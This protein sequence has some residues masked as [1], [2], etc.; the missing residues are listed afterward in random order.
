MSI[1]GGQSTPFNGYYEIKYTGSGDVPNSFTSNSYTISCNG[2]ATSAT[3][4]GFFY[5]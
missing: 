4:S 1:P 3:I 2:T 5:K